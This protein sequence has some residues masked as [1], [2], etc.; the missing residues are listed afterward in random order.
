MDK[1]LNELLDRY[2]KGQLT[3][4]EQNLLEEKTKQS[5]AFRQ[6]VED[7]MELVDSMVEYGQ[8][9]QIKRKLQS[10][11]DEVAASEE[12]LQTKSIAPKTVK[13][14]RFWAVSAVAA[15]VALISVLGTV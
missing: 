2:A 10:V 15:S 6:I 7:H 4:E 12:P 9:A 5:E 1:E 8:H 3:A 14:N 11:H 13:I